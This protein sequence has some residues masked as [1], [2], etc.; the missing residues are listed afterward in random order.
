M[1]R[2]GNERSCRSGGWPNYELRAIAMMN[3][4]ASNDESGR[5]NVVLILPEDLGFCEL[6]CYGS[7][8]ATPNIDRLAKGGLRYNSFHATPLCSPTRA[9]LLT[10]R[11]HHKVAMGFLST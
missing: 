8:I 1:L 3:R 6:G 5:P 2:C 10:G 11:N 4:Q 7:E 9:S